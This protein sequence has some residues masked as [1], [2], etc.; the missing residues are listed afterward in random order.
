MLLCCGEVYSHSLSQFCNWD[1]RHLFIPSITFFL[2]SVLSKKVSVVHILCMLDGGSPSHDQYSHVHHHLPA[3]SLQIVPDQL[4]RSQS[5]EP[6]FQR[7]RRARCVEG[8]LLALVQRLSLPGA[9]RPK[10]TEGKSLMNMAKVFLFMHN[11]LVFKIRISP[12]LDQS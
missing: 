12:L 2:H 11:Q 6:A 4:S 9:E 1:N 8:R 10:I 5:G 7:R 3:F